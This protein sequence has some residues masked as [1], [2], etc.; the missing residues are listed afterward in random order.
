MIVT[1]RA[2]STAV[3]LVSGAAF[4]IVYVV[5]VRTRRGQ[6]LE[7]LA[8]DASEYIDRPGG[9]LSLVT[10][11]NIAVALL[12]I[13]VVGLAFGRVRPAVRAVGMIALANVLTQLL[14]YGLLSRPDFLETAEANT[15]PSGHTVAFASVLLGLLIVLPA[16]PRPIV[17]LLSCVVLGIVT[18]QLL[19]FGWHRASDVIA[20]LL[21]VTGLIAL[22]QLLLPDRAPA[23]IG[24]RSMSFTLLLGCGV[25]LLLGTASIAAAL[26]LD[27]G[28]SQALL[29]ASQLLCL[30]GVVVAVVVTLL[31]QRTIS[32]RARPAAQS[33]AATS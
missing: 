29:L 11:P 1:S 20:G 9:L 19:A 25:L 27:I 16:R 4:L 14:K 13:V 17:G 23:R 33:A 28:G 8:L 10:V 3:L 6:D 15:L 18:F 26:A 5:G 7:N 2:L 31:L 22:A 12:A 32:R 21:L 24:G 30:T